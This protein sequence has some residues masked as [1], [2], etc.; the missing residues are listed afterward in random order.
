[1]RKSLIVIMILLLAGFVSAGIVTEKKAYCGN[2]ILEAGEECDGL[3]IQDICLMLGF[4]SGTLNCY[5]NCTLD[6]RGCNF[7]C[8][9]TWE[10]LSWNPCEKGTQERICVDLNHCGTLR[11]KPETTRSCK[12]TGITGAVVGVLG[13]VGVIITLVFV[14]IILALSILLVILKGN[15]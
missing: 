4:D 2:D 6:M 11:I 3:D 9:E 1:M 7:D 10:C 14:F 12:K 5:S 13:P 8:D 15:K